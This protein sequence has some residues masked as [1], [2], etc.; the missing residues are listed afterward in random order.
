M[1]ADRD[2]SGPDDPLGAATLRKAARRL[3]PFLCLLYAF[4]ILD[5]A[6]VGFART[7]MERDLG[8]SAGVFDLGYGLF[9]LGYLAFEVPSNLLLRKVGARRWIGRIMISWGLVSCATAAVSD[10][11]GFYLVRVLLGVA[12]AGF[13]PGII[14]YLSYWFPSRDRARVTAYFMFAIPMAS[15]FGNPLSGWIMQHLDGASG[16]KGWQW[17]FLLEGL[18]SVLLGVATLFLLTDRPEDARWLAEDERAWLGERIR[19]EEVERRDRHGADRLLAMM[20][21]RV[22]LLIALYFTVAVGSNAAGAH[23]PKLIEKQFPESEKGEIGLLTA[24]PHLCAMVAMALFSVSSDRTGERRKHV[25]LAALL[26]AGGWSLSALAPSPWLVLLGFC[27]A[28]AGMMS[29]LP[30]FWALPT[31]FLSGAA[32]A[33]GI[34]LINSVANI[35]GLFGPTILGQFGLWSMAATLLTGAGLALCVRHE[36]AVGGSPHA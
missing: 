28:Q 4:N 18:P 36:T 32:A 13:F 20:D 26:A 33:G 19:R 25:A 14:L 9:Y 21:R 1:P 12:E 3:I 17:L 7:E 29:M 10:A 35:G 24:L 6:N 5:R 27:V 34:A 15:V 11:W 31:S 2:Q 8:M 23:V 16:V 22:W 30:T